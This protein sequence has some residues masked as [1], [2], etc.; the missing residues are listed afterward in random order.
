MEGGA[1][2]GYPLVV[3]GRRSHDSSGRALATTRGGEL[4]VHREEED[5]KV[6]HAKI[7]H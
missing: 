2:R 6:L 4:M 7:T 3:A 1:A 5:N